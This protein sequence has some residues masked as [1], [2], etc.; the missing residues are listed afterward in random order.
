MGT[1]WG[2]YGARRG[3]RGT[4]L[5][6]HSQAAQRVVSQDGWPLRNGAYHLQ[7][8][9]GAG[10]AAAATSSRHRREHAYM[11]RQLVRR[12]G[13]CRRQPLAC[14]ASTPHRVAFDR[15][16][17]IAIRPCRQR[18]WFAGPGGLMGMGRLIEPRPT[19]PKSLLLQLIS[20][21]ALMKSRVAA[22]RRARRRVRR[23]V[24]TECHQ[25][26][27]VESPKP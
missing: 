15:A 19:E 17:T 6:Q 1:R 10:F 12:C 25:P 18:P 8:D 20:S 13:G 2:T 3:A 11:V 26:A 16:V 24:H 9:E 21:G 5:Q 14:E 4:T 22:S 23:P 7:R 27:S